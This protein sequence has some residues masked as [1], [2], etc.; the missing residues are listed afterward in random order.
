MS[1]KGITKTGKACKKK[2]SDTGYCYLHCEDSTNKT[3]K[4][5]TAPKKNITRKV[6]TPK[7]IGSR[8]QLEPHWRSNRK[9]P[10]M[11]SLEWSPSKNYADDMKKMSIVYPDKKWLPLPPGFKIVYDKLMD[12]CKSIPFGL[13]DFHLNMPGIQ[14]NNERDNYENNKAAFVEEMHTKGNHYFH[15]VDF[16]DNMNYPPFDRAYCM[17]HEWGTVKN[18]LN[19]LELGLK[20]DDDKW[21][22]IHGETEPIILPRIISLPFREKILADS[23]DY[24]ASEYKIHLQPKPE[25]QIPVLKILAKMIAKD[26]IF[27]SYIEN[28]KSIIPYN[29]VTKDLN[30]PVIVI[31]PVWGHKGISY[32]LDK[33][34]KK[35]S[36]YD[37]KEIGLNHTP[38]FNYKI[39]GEVAGLV[40]YANGSGDHKKIL[41]AKFFTGPGKEFYKGQHQPM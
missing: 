31:Y 27:S 36:K 19:T 1:C 14:W 34:V 11:G 32:V 4:K 17:C 7:K 24:L 37:C 30:L 16:K 40:Y 39:G 15:K 9:S 12:V 2:P 25:Y 41:P 28:W 3:P 33:I 29:R 20:G 10:G 21:Q 35:F 8:K 5:V 6:I 38:R 18:I 26:P 22:E 23:I 13:C